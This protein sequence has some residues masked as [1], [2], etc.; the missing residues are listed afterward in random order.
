M[1][2]ND[3]IENKT[4]KEQNSNMVIDFSSNI[5]KINKSN[6]IILDY[7]EVTDILNMRLDKLAYAVYGSE[8]FM[9]MLAKFNNISNPFEVKTGDVIAIPDKDSLYENTILLNQKSIMLP[10]S[11]RKNITSSDE[12][13]SNV[14]NNK[15]VPTRKKSRKSNFIKTK[16]GGLIF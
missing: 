10:K 12:V 14:S 1:I 8:D 6:V 3:I 4:V 16:D 2:E 9:F 15:K 7:I 13:N 11:R 5:V